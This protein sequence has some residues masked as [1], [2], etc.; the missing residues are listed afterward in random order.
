[1]ALGSFNAVAGLAADSRS[2]LQA[3]YDAQCS[4]AISKDVVAFQKFFSPSFVAT[5]AAGRQQTLAQIVAIIQSPP[6]GFIV[7]SCSFAIRS[8]SIEN[9]SAT[10]L[11]TRTI[12]GAVVQGVITEPFTQVQNS[13]D[14]WALSGSPVET[15]STAT[16][17]RTTYGGKIVDQRGTLPATPPLP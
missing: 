8:I 13:S 15:T 10:V 6:Q 17:V 14:T 16:G 5:D 7:G 12:S 3:A 1:M 4:S 9:G 2:Q 11:V